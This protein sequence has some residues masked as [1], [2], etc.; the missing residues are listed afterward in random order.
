[1]CF[2][3]RRRI[4]Q[5]THKPAGHNFHKPLRIKLLFSP[6]APLFVVIYSFVRYVRVAARAEFMSEA[7]INQGINGVNT[8][9]NMSR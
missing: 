1:M 5:R 8:A 7:R 3:G 9:A 4:S 2:Q 6:A